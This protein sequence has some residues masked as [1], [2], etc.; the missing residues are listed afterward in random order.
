MVKD[1][2]TNYE[3]ADTQGVMDGKLQPFI[4]SYLQWLLSQE[5]PE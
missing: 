4:Y 3:T 2:R 5:N 1:L